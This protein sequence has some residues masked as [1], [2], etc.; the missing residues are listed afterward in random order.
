MKAKKIIICVLA[1]VMLAGTAAGG[2]NERQKAGNKTLIEQGL[3]LIYLMKEKAGNEKYLSL[4]MGANDDMLG[5]IR[6]IS[7]GDITKPLEVYRIG[8]DF[9]EFLQQVIGMAMKGD[10]SSSLRDDINKSF[11][12]SFASMWSGRTNG[13]MGLAAMSVLQTQ[14][15]FDSDEIKEDCIYVYVFH[16]SYPVAVSFLRGEGKAVRASAGYVLDKDFPLSLDI[17]LNEKDMG[18]KIERVK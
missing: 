17:M 18:I 7:K 13:A 5:K 12:S 4:I 1:A 15:V 8:G 16:D 2:G 9:S 11:L 6:E 3:S 14:T 10:C